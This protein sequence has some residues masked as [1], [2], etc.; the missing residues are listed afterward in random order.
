MFYYA[1]TLDHVQRG[2]PI[3]Y[4]EFIR[5]VNKK[6]PNIEHVTRYEE[7]KQGRLHIHGMIKA[8]KRMYVNRIHPG[9]G[10][11]F[12]FEPV[13]SE[14]AWSMYINKDIKQEAQ[15]LVKW[16]AIEIDFYS[17]PELSITM[18][19]PCDEP[20]EYIENQISS[21]FDIRKLLS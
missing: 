16:K 5:D 11:S 8:Q 2:L 10:Y 12:K 19:Q 15:L 14:I 20:C 18:V 21:G 7:G 9:E 6:Y 3:D 13:K 17:V 1:Y 4:E